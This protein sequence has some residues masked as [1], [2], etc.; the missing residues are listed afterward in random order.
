M[1]LSKSA[2]YRSAANAANHAAT[3]HSVGN[4]HINH[5]NGVGLDRARWGG[6]S[7]S[8]TADLLGFSTQKS[9]RFTQN[10]VK[11]KKGKFYRLKCILNARLVQAVK[12]ATVTTTVRYVE[13]NLEVE[14]LTTAGDLK[15]GGR[16]PKK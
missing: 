16:L 1:H 7:I 13:L 9:L 11:Q 8:I 14:D 2:N 6:L 5:Q 15:T 12:K 10:G 4:A 3:G